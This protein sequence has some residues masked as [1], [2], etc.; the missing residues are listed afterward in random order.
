MLAGVSGRQS[1][2]MQMLRL[3]A[4]FTRNPDLAFA[5]LRC[6]HIGHR[7]ATRISHT[8]KFERPFAPISI[9]AV[10]EPSGSQHVGGGLLRFTE[11]RSTACLCVLSGRI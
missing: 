6:V 9:A 4:R 3:A 8:K 11:P 5:P 7:D 1:S 2:L 10:A